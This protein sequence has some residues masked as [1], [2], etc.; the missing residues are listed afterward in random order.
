MIGDRLDVAS[1]V[2]MTID[3]AHSKLHEGDHYEYTEFFS[4]GDGNE[5]ELI[6]I[7]PNTTKWAHMLFN[8]IGALHTTVEIFED[9]TWA[10]TGT[11][12]S[13]KIMNN[14]RNSSNE[15]GLEIRGKGATGTDADLIFSSQF[16]NDSG[17]GANRLVSGGTARGDAERILKQNSKYLLTI[18]SL[19]AVNELAI[20]LSWYENISRG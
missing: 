5:K 8:V 11:D 20:V 2:L 15:S 9:T 4:L 7:T 19:S 10:S 18:T 14:N 1:D 17:V 3:L 6:I 16:G 12:F 13:A